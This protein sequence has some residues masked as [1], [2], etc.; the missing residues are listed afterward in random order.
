[1]SGGE[2]QASSIVA[3]GPRLPLGAAVWVSV[4]LHGTVCKAVSD[5]QSRIECSQ[6]PCVLRK[7]SVHGLARYLKLKQMKLLWKDMRSLSSR[8]AKAMGAPCGTKAMIAQELENFFS[9]GIVHD[10]DDNLIEVL[11]R[12]IGFIYNAGNPFLLRPLVPLPPPSSNA[13]AS[14]SSV[15]TS[16]HP[17]FSQTTA[18]T[19]TSNTVS[20]P[21]NLAQFFP[22]RVSD[23]KPST[24]TAAGAFQN[25]IHN[26]PR[27]ERSSLTSSTTGAST[28]ALVKRERNVPWRPQTPMDH[29]LIQRLNQMG[30][31]DKHELYNSIDRL[32]EKNNA[33]IL[34]SADAVMF[35]IIS[36][37]QDLEEAKIMDQARLQSEQLRKEEARRRRQLTQQQF[38]CILQTSD[39]QRWKADSSMF[40]RSWLL[41]DSN[42]VAL[43]QQMSSNPT[44]KLNLL[45]LLKLEKEAYKWYGSCLPKHYFLD[46]V[47]PQMMQST[48]LPSLVRETISTLQKAFYS[49]SHQT[50]G[51]P[52]IL[53]EAKD[54]ADASTQKENHENDSDDDVVL[55]VPKYKR[56]K[57]SPPGIATDSSSGGSGAATVTSSHDVIEIL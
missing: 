38:E 49:L 47:I 30:F 33:N 36:V 24:G 57:S 29:A 44:D 56:L 53:L 23:N 18:S 28:A 26:L 2:A 15:A 42:I 20:A 32:V 34:P 9:N 31:H 40:P 17:G 45:E 46:R 10:A 41:S 51:V 39:I 12:K 19:A 54:A 22:G 13:T 4:R 5:N 11:F 48:D 1:M 27:M 7:M 3:P 14:G 37:R 43:F 50:N 6:S 16:S 52:K 8:H 21:T 55:V 35:D 25:N